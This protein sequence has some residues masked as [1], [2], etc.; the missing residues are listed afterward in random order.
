MAN[1][2]FTRQTQKLTD[3]FRFSYHVQVP[4]EVWEL[5]YDWNSKK[6]KGSFRPKRK[7]QNG[8]KKT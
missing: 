2:R 4:R 1:L 7:K 3:A 5:P 6:K 8:G